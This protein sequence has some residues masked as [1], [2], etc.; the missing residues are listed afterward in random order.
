MSRPAL[1]TCSLMLSAHSMICRVNISPK[2]TVKSEKMLAAL[3]STYM[4]QCPAHDSR[5][6]ALPLFLYDFEKIGEP[7]KEVTPRG[8][9]IASYNCSNSRNVGTTNQVKDFD[10]LVHPTRG[11]HI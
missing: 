4:G 10:C 8:Q 9:W 6:Q 1:Y 7:G 11:T 5:S 3:P 2:D